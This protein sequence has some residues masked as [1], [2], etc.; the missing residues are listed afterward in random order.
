MHHLQRYARYPLLLL[1]II[2]LPYRIPF[3]FIHGKLPHKVELEL[4]R[5]PA[6][7]HQAMQRGAKVLVLTAKLLQGAGH[8]PF[9]LST[10]P[11]RA[12]SQTVATVRALHLFFLDLEHLSRTLADSHIP[13]RLILYPATGQFF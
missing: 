2:G 11:C 6:Q 5:F 4:V 10:H 13:R 7:Q 9:G 12:D 8:E 3:V 1:A